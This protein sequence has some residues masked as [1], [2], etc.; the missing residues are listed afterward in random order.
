MGEKRY[1]AIRTDKDN[2]SLLLDELRAGRLRQGW[3]YNPSQ[4]L[5]LI[6]K[7]I[8]LGGK[9]WERITE[10]QKEALPHIRMLSAANDSVKKGDWVLVPNLPEY[11]SFFVA[12]IVGDYYFSLLELAEDIHNVGGRDYGHVL[13][14]RLIT[15]QG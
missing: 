3:G 11:G 7:E 1:W 13:P 5:K 15:E 4:D 14:V 12:E 10:E 8:D 6:Q 2:K 9:W